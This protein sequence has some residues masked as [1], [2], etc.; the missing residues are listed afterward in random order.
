[1][2]KSREPEHRAFLTWLIQELIAHQVDALVVAGD[3]FDTG[4]PASYARSLYFNF[5]K[6]AAKEWG[7]QIIIVGGNHDSVSTLNESSAVL[8]LANTTVI[9]GACED[10][11]QEIVVLDKLSGEAGAVIAAVPYLRDR[12][13]RLSNDDERA[14]DKSNALR[15]GIKNHYEE[16]Y[17]LAQELASEKEL[18]IIATGHLTTQGGELT[19]G[20]REL[21]IGTLEGYASDDFPSDFDYIA[22]GHLHK[23]QIMGHKEHIRYCG[24]PIPLSFIEAQY[25]RS[26][27]LVEIKKGEKPLVEE[28]IVPT[29][30]K[31]ISLSGK[32]DKVLS[33]LNNLKSEEAA[34]IWV[35]VQIE[36]DG[37]EGNITQQINKLIEGSSLEVLRIKRIRQSS[38]VR[39]NRVNAEKLHEMTVDE[40]FERRIHLTTLSPEQTKKVTQL[41]HQVRSQV[42]EEV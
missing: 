33:E 19:E 30:Q 9:G 40:V 6:Q 22:L 18:P 10:I 37:T 25:D 39:L 34:N 23:K 21:Y 36:L 14:D 41:F 4:T 13:V 17:Q 32:I 5:L 7:G 11:A 15:K 28:L 2:N 20:V 31:L 26:V 8:E 27:N 16:A 12:D 42:E 24:S 38:E 3:I 1:M 29:S 35:E